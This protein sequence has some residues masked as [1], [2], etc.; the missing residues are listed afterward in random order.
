M[1]AQVFNPSC[2]GQISFGK[3]TSPPHPHSKGEIYHIITASSPRRTKNYMYV[4]WF[5]AFPE[6]SQKML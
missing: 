2:E 3:T 5:H 1:T 6:S 4:N